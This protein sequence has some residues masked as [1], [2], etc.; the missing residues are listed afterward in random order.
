MIERI[1][2]AR[3]KLENVQAKEAQRS[4]MEIPGGN[5]THN[6]IEPEKIYQK[7]RMGDRS[8]NKGWRSLRRSLQR[9][10]FEIIYY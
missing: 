9:T 10:I 2:A 6:P 5:R 8:P 4:F 7:E 3:T 1:Y